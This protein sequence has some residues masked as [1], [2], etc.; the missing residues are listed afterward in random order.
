MANSLYQATNYQEFLKREFP[1]IG[2]DRGKR[3]RLSEYLRCQTSFVSQV[4][5]GYAHF[6]VEHILS[7]SDFLALNPEEK[8][9]LVLLLQRDRAGTK[10]LRDYFESKLEK[11]RSKLHVINEHLKVK[12]VPESLEQYVYYSS[13]MHSA[14]HILCALP[15]FSTID[16]LKQHIGGP[17]ESFNQA[18][19]FLEQSNFIEREGT[20]L[21]IKRTRVHLEPNSPMILK[22]HANWR[23]KAIESFEKT[24]RREDL[25]FTAIYG[26]SKQ[27]AKQIRLELL[28]QLKNIE[29]TVIQSKE[30]APY[31]FLLDFWE[32]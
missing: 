17:A 16:K 29:S 7:V 24:K 11:K 3:K 19:E 1:K 12:D 2:K 14:C 30:E 27:D 28:Q 15:Q 23:F 8:E 32:F 10:R 18:I 6:S 13:W 31:V 25:H 22:H 20:K 21:K 9:Y 26:I 5:S 4:I